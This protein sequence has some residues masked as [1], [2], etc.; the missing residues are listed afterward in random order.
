M[1]VLV[2]VLLAA[3]AQAVVGK[4]FLIHLYLMAKRDL[5]IIIGIIVVAIGLMIMGKMAGKGKVGMWP[6]TQIACLQNGHENLAIHIHPTLKITVNGVG[7]E[8]PANIGLTPT[9][10]AEIHTHDGTGTIH[11]ESADKGKASNFTLKD[12]FAVYG[13]PLER[14]GYVVTAMV[15]GKPVSDLAMIPLR[16]HEAIDLAYVSVATSTKR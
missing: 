10:M 2:A 15:A 7:E 8:V 14:E 9:C 13:K 16:D 6:N 1:A 5:Y 4:N 11:I 3:E 12:F